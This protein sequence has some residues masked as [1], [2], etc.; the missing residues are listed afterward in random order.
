M[1]IGT[2]CLLEAINQAARKNG[3]QFERLVLGGFQSIVL[4]VSSLVKKS[5]CAYRRRANI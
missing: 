5:L 3:V 4:E 1:S 2:V